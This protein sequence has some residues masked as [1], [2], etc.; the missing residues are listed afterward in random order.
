[1]ASGHTTIDI[2]S[3]RIII[4]DTSGIKHDNDTELNAA[5]YLLYSFL[6]REVYK[7]HD[8]NFGINDTSKLK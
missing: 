2:E 6:I 5:M 3:D 7:N 1:L 8:A 4:F